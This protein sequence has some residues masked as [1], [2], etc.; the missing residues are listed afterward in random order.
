MRRAAAVAAALPTAALVKL[1]VAP[2][3]LLVAWD[4]DG[5]LINHKRG[6]VPDA[7][8]VFDER[9]SLYLRPHAGAVLRVLGA[10]RNEQVLFTAATRPYADSIVNA[11]LPP[12]VFSRRLYREELSA[13]THGKD[14]ARLGAPLAR[15]LL[16]DDQQRN[17]V[18]AQHFLLVEPYRIGDAA[19]VT[20]W[21]VA[22]LVLLHNVIGPAAF[23]FA[24]WL[25]PRAPAPRL[26]PAGGGGEKPRGAPQLA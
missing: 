18:G 22:A 6:R 20:L 10:A 19:D 4:L 25:S 14:L 24:H 2:D 1:A 7:D 15:V 17:R 5:T 8:H 9:Y 13:S 3:P 11:L 26:L 23:D 21:G 12:G 16:V